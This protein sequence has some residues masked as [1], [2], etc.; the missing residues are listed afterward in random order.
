MEDTTLKKVADASKHKYLGAIVTSDFN[1][2][3]QSLITCSK[4]NIL[5]SLRVMLNIKIKM[6]FYY[7]INPTVF[8]PSQIR[9]SFVIPLFLNEYR[10]N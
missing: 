2:F 6:L 8:P 7:Y 1:F 4:V 9:R 3:K 10:K 5:G